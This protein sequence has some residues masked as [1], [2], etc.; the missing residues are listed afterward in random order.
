[1]EDIGYEMF[2][3]NLENKLGRGQLMYVEKNMNPKQV[4]IEGR[5]QEMLLVEIKLNGSDKLLIALIYRSPSS[6]EENNKQLN[7]AMNSLC[8][9][10]YSHLLLTGDFNYKNINWEYMTAEGD[11]ENRFLDT[12]LENCLTQQVDQITRRRTHEESSLLDLVFTNEDN[13]VEEISYNSPLGKSDHLCLIFDIQCYWK[14]EENGKPKRFFIVPSM[15][16]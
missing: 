7:D 12:T 6:D 3:M 5:F 13:M 10:G 16:T 11:T 4:Y 15:T 14:R 2:E 1:L 9:L 8:K